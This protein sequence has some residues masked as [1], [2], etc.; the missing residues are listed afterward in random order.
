MCVV[1]SIA[2]YLP[3]PEEPDSASRCTHSLFSA[4]PVPVP[5]RVPVGP[6]SALVQRLLSRKHREPVLLAT[7]WDAS[8]ASFM[9]RPPR[10]RSWPRWRVR[11]PVTR[12]PPADVPPYLLIGRLNV[13]FRSWIFR[14][15]CVVCRAHGPD[16][17][18]TR[19]V[20]DDDDDVGK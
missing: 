10:P 13:Y 11:A 6:W 18:W 17:I 5:W 1:H 20:Y 3:P 7:N 4:F 19:N 12:R 14:F 2:L 16:E 8:Y 9:P 15:E